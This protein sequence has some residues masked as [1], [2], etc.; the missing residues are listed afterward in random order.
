MVQPALPSSSTGKLL[1]GT[2][3][4]F[5]IVLNPPILSIANQATTTV[6]IA[7]LWLYAVGWGAVG[8]TA[9]VIAAYTNAFRLDEDQIPPELREDSVGF[10]DQTDSNP[11][12]GQTYGGDR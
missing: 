1:L 8:I 6:G 2:L 7:T 12:A 5:G 11:S 3:I 10:E 9:L 4:L